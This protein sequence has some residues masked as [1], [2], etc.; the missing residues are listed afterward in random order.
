MEKIGN[1]KVSQIDR[2]S[3]VETVKGSNSELAI[4]N[5]SIPVFIQEL[6]DAKTFLR[7]L[8]LFCLAATSAA[9]IRRPIEKVRRRLRL[10]SIEGFPRPPLRL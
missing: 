10:V 1:S 7:L 5:L 9:P 8:I 2:V 3:L 6:S 4:S